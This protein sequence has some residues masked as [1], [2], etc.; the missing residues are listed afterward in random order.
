MTHALARVCSRQYVSLCYTHLHRLVHTFIYVTVVVVVVVIVE[1]PRAIEGNFQ[2]TIHTGCQKLRC[3]ELQENIRF[4]VPKRKRL[5]RQSTFMYIHVCMYLYK[6]SLRATC[7]VVSN[8]H[9]TSR[10]KQPDN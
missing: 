6:V 3:G 2:R 1:E 10:E 8:I 5:T 4:R 7:H 9:K